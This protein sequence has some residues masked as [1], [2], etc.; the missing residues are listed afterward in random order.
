MLLLKSNLKSQT[1]ILQEYFVPLKHLLPFINQIKRILRHQQATLLNC[2]IRLVHKEKNLLT[3]AT[4]PMVAVVLYLNQKISAQGALRM[5]KL[6]EL[7]V[8]AALE[9]NGTF[10]LPYQ[11]YF[12][13]DQL[14]MAYPQWDTFVAKKQKYD[15]Q[16]LFVNNL[17]EKY[18]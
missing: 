3:Y 2:S 9:N 6:T 10:F 8:D 1:D 12:T 7:L 15:P 18:K 5:Q 13:R 17:Y 11:L 4:E 16:E 14:V